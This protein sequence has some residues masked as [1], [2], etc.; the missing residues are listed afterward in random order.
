MRLRDGLGDDGYTVTYRVI[1]ADSHPVSGG[2]VFVVGDARRAGHDGRRAA[3]RRRAGPVTGTAF[4][5]VRAVQFARHRARAR[6]ADL[7]ARVLA[8]G[9][10]RPRARAGLEAASR[11]PAPLRALVLA[12]AAAGALL[13]GAAIVLQ[14]AVAGG[15]TSGTRSAPTSIGDVLDTRFGLFWG[16]RLVAWLVSAGAALASRRPV[17]APAARCHSSRCALR[18]RRSAAT[19]ACSRRSPCCCPPTSCTWSR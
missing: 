7:P 13:G 14:G 9:L 12:A 8:A 2:F 17:G 10:R 3:R 4:G 15:T 19:R 5:V 18:C 1:S 6:R 11:V 16:A